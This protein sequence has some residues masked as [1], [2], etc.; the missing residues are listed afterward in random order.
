ME[1]KIEF[2]TLDHDVQVKIVERLICYDKCHIEHFNG[3]NWI[4]P[5]YCICA[6]YPKDYWISQDFERED[7]DLDGFDY[8]NAWF[9]VT[10]YW[11]DMTDEQRIATGNKFEQMTNLF[12]ELVI[13]KYV[14]KKETLDKYHGRKTK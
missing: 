9:N 1:K 14:L 7:F 5:N 11:D 6:T 10:Q 13:Q 3:E 2:T 12:I 8:N 4:T